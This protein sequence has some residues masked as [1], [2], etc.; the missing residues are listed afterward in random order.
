MKKLTKEEQTLID[1]SER[2]VRKMEDK[3]EVVS[4][5]IYV[6]IMRY[7]NRLDRQIKRDVEKVMSMPPVELPDK[8]KTPDWLLEKKMKK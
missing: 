6:D 7:L 3:H 1:D 8:Y 5:D 2:W 4:A